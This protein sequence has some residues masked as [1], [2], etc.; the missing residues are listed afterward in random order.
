MQL[1]VENERKMQSGNKNKE[2][3]LKQL[4]IFTRCYSYMAEFMN[5]VTLFINLALIITNLVK[6]CM[7]LMYGISFHSIT[8]VFSI[9]PEVIVK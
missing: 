4:Q 7:R 3:F 8:M 1:Y 5:L 2:K 9:I 6:Y